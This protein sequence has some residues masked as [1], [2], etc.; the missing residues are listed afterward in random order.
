MPGGGSAAGGS[1]SG[2]LSV[3]GPGNGAPPA[4]PSPTGAGFAGGRSVQAGQV[5]GR[6]PTAEGSGDGGFPEEGGRA[7]GS[8]ATGFP[9]SASA[10]DPVP[11][12]DFVEGSPDGRVRGDSAAS[13][14][15]GNGRPRSGPTPGGTLR[16]GDLEA[17][18]AA[19]TGASRAEAARYPATLLELGILQMTGL[20]T[21]VHAPDPVRAFQDALR[22][23]DRD[24]ADAAAGRLEAVA[25]CVAAW[26]AAGSG[27]RRAL[28]AG[29]RRELLALFAELGAETPVLPQTLLYEDVREEEVGA[30]LEQWT[31]LAAEPLAALTGILPAF[32][33]ALPQR[34]TLKGFFLARYGRG[35]RCDDLLRLVH[36]FHEDIF[37]QYLSFTATKPR[38]AADGSHAQEENWLGMP[39]VTALD[40]ARA[41]FTGRLRDLWDGHPAGA[42]EL[43][44]DEATIEAVAAELAPVRGTFAP[45]SHFVQLAARPDDPLVVLNNSYGGLSF[46]FTRFTHCFD[47]DPADGTGTAESAGTQP[48]DSGPLTA[49][50][51]ATLRSLQPPGAVFAEITAGSATTNLNLHSRLTDHEIVCPGE[52]STAPAA[53]RLD[54]DDL[55]AEHDAAADRL[56]LRSR[57]LGAEVIPLYLGYLVPMV[58]PE[59]PRTLLLF[60]PTS[61][62]HPEMWRGVPEAPAVAGVTTRPR[63]RYRSLVVHRRS[64]T[65]A[66][67][68]LPVR[69]PGTDDAAHYLAWQE[70]R[71]R[72]GLP[73]Q[74]FATVHD[75]DAPAFGNAKPQYVDF[76]SPLSLLALDALTG[77]GRSRTVFEEMLPARSDLHVRSARGHHVAELAVEIVPGPGRQDS[78]A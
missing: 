19:E 45:H 8:R 30:G 68:A 48:G 56:V 40:R 10:S 65:A 42:P 44:L 55:Y 53:A 18:L 14:R 75:D 24:W 73:D 52:T 28:L 35:G 13:I 16:W 26:R 31:A 70:W 38:W 61:R 46:P 49:E 50:L 21:D 15:F 57:R 29:L 25:G 20:E 54:L 43:R 58:L 69:E 17:W 12:D 64:W 72:H 9:G 3:G 1:R 37:G 11:G 2:V 5:R 76:D 34:L 7:D 67:G 33:V 27:E 6:G 60:S 62:A 71:H 23:L 51:R 36:D 74:V 32:D 47:D 59:V 63:I 78:P 4:G 77:G 66:P 39:E 22:G 41:E